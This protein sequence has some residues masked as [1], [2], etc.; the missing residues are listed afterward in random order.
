LKA[1]KFN[2]KRQDRAPFST[3]NN[4]FAAPLTR[5]KMKTSRLFS[6]TLST[7][8]D[9][10]TR[11]SDK[12]A[13]HPALLRDHSDAHQRHLNEATAVRHQHRQVEQ[14]RTGV[15]KMRVSA[16]DAA[17]E[18]GRLGEKIAKLAVQF[19]S[20]RAWLTDTSA[21]IKSRPGSVYSESAFVTTTA[22]ASG[23][24]RLSTAGLES[25]TAALDIS[26]PS[27]VLLKSMHALQQLHQHWALSML[28]M[29]HQLQDAFAAELTGFVKGSVRTARY[30]THEFLKTFAAYHDAVKTANTAAE[31]AEQYEMFS[32]EAGSSDDSD[33][34]VSTVVSERELSAPKRFLKRLRNK[35]RKVKTQHNQEMAVKHAK[36][37]VQARK[38]LKETSAVLDTAERVTQDRFE[39]VDAEFE[40]QHMPRL[41]LVRL[42][43]LICLTLELYAF[44]KDI[45][46]RGTG[47]VRSD[48]LGPR[49]G[50]VGGNFGYP[51]R[52]TCKVAR[53]A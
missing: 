44:G 15:K 9:H 2:Q 47:T 37:F 25:M 22:H 27:E 6:R 20:M 42:L 11:D 4:L 36:R 35:T 30:Q 17:L 28:G 23:N 10:R 32:T 52:R 33:S 50:Y 19:E 21:E 43:L 3:F 12:T 7:I 48:A 13:L 41:M 24:V 8:N 18:C 51:K 49:F 31:M 46:P 5:E 34:D 16:E 14:L 45:F 40:S 26:D 38:Q 1:A 29:Q 39:T 53:A